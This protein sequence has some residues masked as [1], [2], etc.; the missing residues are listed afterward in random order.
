[1]R[2]T[3]FAVVLLFFMFPLLSN[4]ETSQV[5]TNPPPNLSQESKTIHLNQADVDMLTQSFKGIGR[6]R[7]EAIVA[8]REANGPFKSI[9]DL[10]LVKGIGKQFVSRNL[11]QLQE[12]YSID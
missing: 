11:Q 7:A 3:L 8:Y 9:E 4:A 2:A 10:A 1:M 6:K 12:T 5:N